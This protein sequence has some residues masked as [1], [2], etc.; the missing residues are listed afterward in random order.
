MLNLIGMLAEAR[1][2]FVLVG[3]V[4]VGLQGCHRPTTNLDVALAMDTVNVQRFLSV[5][6]FFGLRPTLPVEPNALAQPEML[7]QWHREKGVR[8]FGLRGPVAEETVVNVLF[9]PIVPYAD[10]RRD[11]AMIDVGPIEIPVASIAHLIALKTDA[12]RSQDLTDIE[13]LRKAHPQKAAQKQN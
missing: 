12:G 11:A 6:Q 5:A 4:A 1:V 3:G 2:E 10:L 8:V 13:A 7:E 9:R